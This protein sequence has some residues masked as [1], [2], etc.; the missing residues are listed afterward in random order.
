LLHGYGGSYTEWVQLTDLVAFTQHLPLIVVMPEGG[1]GWYMDPALPG[2][3][4]ETYHIGELIPYIDNHFRTVA[5]RR[6][7]AVAGLSM[8]GMGAFVYAARHPDLFVA[9][10]SIS[11]I[12]D[13]EN[14]NPYFT[15][16]QPSPSQVFAPVCGQS[17][18]CLRAHDPVDLVSNLRGLHL[19]LSCGNGKPGPFDG[20][21]DAASGKVEA[22]IHTT[23]ESMAAA[24]RGA[25]IPATADD[26][27]PGTHSWPYFQR[28]LHRAM[29]MLMA[30]FAKPPAAP[31]NWSYRTAESS[32]GVWGYTIRVTRAT[33][34]G[35]Y[36]DLAGVGPRSFTVSGS[37][38]ITLIT[39]PI[40]VAGHTYVIHRNNAGKTAVTADSHGRLH[41]TIQLGNKLSTTHIGIG[42]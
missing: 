18:W 15:G 27:G 2:P 20:T 13:A 11:G 23:L 33:D 14:Y 6:G 16:A 3:N 30:T 35:G 39:A 10:A 38:T 24:L 32:A 25:H 8:G 5:T 34:D 36:T 1:I 42:S 29:P 4:W 28:E 21:Y 7:R 9:A 37:G 31:T 40:Y 17:V 41:F 22:S 12:L 19:F 26:Y